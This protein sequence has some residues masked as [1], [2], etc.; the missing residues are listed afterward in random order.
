MP[1]LLLSPVTRQDA[2]RV[3]AYGGSRASVQCNSPEL[4][5][6]ATP[7]VPKVVLLTA[8]RKPLENGCLRLF[9]TAQQVSPGGGFSF[10]QKH[11]ELLPAPG[12]NRDLSVWGLLPSGVPQV[13]TPQT[14]KHSGWTGMG[15]AVL[16]G[17]VRELGPL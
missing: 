14:Q 3:L 16:V 13:Q 1:F 6:Q 15:C 11:A 4:G 10:E 2:R 12:I 9:F 17:S 7:H 5:S 8:W